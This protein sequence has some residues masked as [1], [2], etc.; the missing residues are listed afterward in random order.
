MV[1]ACRWVLRLNT[2]VLKYGKGSKSRQ[3]SPSDFTTG[4][5]LNPPN[6]TQIKSFRWPS[7]MFYEWK[8]S[9]QGCV[10]GQSEGRVKTNSSNVIIKV[11]P[12]PSRNTSSVYV[13]GR[14][15]NWNPIRFLL[16]YQGQKPLDSPVSYVSVSIDTMSLLTRFGDSSLVQFTVPVTPSSYPDRPRPST[17]PRS[18]SSSVRTSRPV[19]RRPSVHKIV[20]TVPRGSQSFLPIPTREWSRIERPQ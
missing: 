19:D 11:D 7:R 8:I 14:R 10:P 2:L 1:V 4:S 12:Y 17:V 6:K 18:T 13:S 15:V 9:S 20:F 16:L 5:N 3:V